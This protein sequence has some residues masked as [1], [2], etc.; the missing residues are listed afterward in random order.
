MLID[1]ALGLLEW[2]NVNEAFASSES[3]IKAI[4]SEPKV[5]DLLYAP[6]QTV[7]W[8]VGVLSD[9]YP[10]HGYA[11]YICQVLREHGMVNKAAKPY[12]VLVRIADIVKV[13]NGK[14]PRQASLGMV[15]CVTFEKFTP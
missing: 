12:T 10:R 1:L 5:K 15:D 2:P 3:A 9:G 14:T 4:K 11:S 8:T 6:N 13:M 7:K